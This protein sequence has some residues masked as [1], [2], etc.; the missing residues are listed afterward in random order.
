MSGSRQAW[1]V[2]RREMRERLR[3][4]A[5]WVGMGFMLLVVV[6]AIV[7]ATALDEDEP[8]RDV[9][10]TGRTA[11]ALPEAVTDQGREADLRVRVHHYD[12]VAAGE[13]A[14]RGEDV[15]VLVVDGRTL[16]WRVDQDERL[17]AVVTGAI[18]QV[19]VRERAAAVGITEEQLIA[20]A[21]PATVDD[22]ELGIAGDRSPA[23]E[24]ATSVIAI[25]LLAALATYGQL[26][27]TGVVQE[28]SS[29]VVEVLLAR[30]SARDLL[31][32]KVVGIGLLGLAQLALTAA[33]ALAATLAIDSVDIPAISGG[34]LG[35]AVVWF[36][37]GYAMYAMAYGALGSLASRTEDASAVSAPASVV[38]IVG[39]WASLVAVSSDPDGAWAHVVSFF[40][41]TAPYAMPARIALGVTSWWEPILAAALALIAIAV[42]V[43]VAGRVY[44]GAVLHTGATLKLRQ[45]WSRSTEPI[46][47]VQPAG[48]GAPRTGIDRPAVAIAAASAGVAVGA[49]LALD[50][51]VIGVAAGAASYAVASRLTR[52]RAQRR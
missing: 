26:V 9:G 23:D 38:L 24:A 1:L 49:F 29:R 46:P 40:P 37:L 4:R 25:V 16:T 44:T 6:A 41:A 45:A 22:R 52:R 17:R 31:M 7:L 30:M 2:A 14:V 39:Y 36:V 42:L 51:V 50:D 15:D 19:T 34:V 21:A 12:D 20:V 47:Q 48:E 3:S 27:L 13:A 5:L 28:K 18:Q 10:F 8:T 43:A 11:Q 33:V 35:W 32:G